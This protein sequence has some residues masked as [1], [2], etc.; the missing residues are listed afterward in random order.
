MKFFFPVAFNNDTDALLNI[1]K[2]LESLGETPK[3]AFHFTLAQ[4]LKQ[5]GKESPGSSA[6][7]VLTENNVAS[8]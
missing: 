7:N 2:E 5:Q 1:T 8:V 4:L 3:A 6:A